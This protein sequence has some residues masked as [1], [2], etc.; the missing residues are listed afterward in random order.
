MSRTDYD[1]EV[2]GCR[3]GH[4][5]RA[6]MVSVPP[7]LIVTFALA[8]VGAAGFAGWWA[9]RSRPSSSWVTKADLDGAAEASEAGAKQLVAKIDRYERAFD[10]LPF[11]VVVGDGSTGRRNKTLAPIRGNDRLGAVLSAAIERQQAPLAHDD[12][13]EMVEFTGP[14]K[15]VFSVT[16]HVPEGSYR[17]TVV[18]VEDLTERTHLESVRRDFVANISHELRTPVG[19]LAV[20][21]E[22]L[23]DE[24]D[25][26]V[27][28][29]L[30]GRL[31]EEAHRV[32]RVIDDLLELSALEGS[33]PLSAQ[34]HDLGDL[35]VEAV[36]RIVPH[37]NARD[38]R[39]AIDLPDDG[40]AAE[41]DRA[42]IVSAVANL[43]DNAVKFSEDGGEVMVNVTRAD[44]Q[45]VIEVVDR[46]VGIPLAERERIFER[47]Y[48]VDKA[49]SRATGG[50]GLGLA[51][52]RHV[53]AN[54]GGEITLDS[55]AGIGSTFRI[56]I[57]AE[58]PA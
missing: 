14:P 32:A 34:R 19:A 9:G 13:G 6:T 45:V 57:P 31:V 49:R 28:E 22:T 11:G 7:V 46:G 1:V 41:V 4:G 17:E 47:F 43:V 55:T 24:P 5:N 3:D 26:V 10:V 38:I 27:V 12:S 56:V 35:V 25:P 39:I 30:S 29:R 53:V 15:R 2:S 48:R 44:E 36:D 37:A 21:A 16:A 58:Q 33:K 51:I 18:V 8:A 54:H 42:Q 20:L 23:Q 52:V 40:P 50:T